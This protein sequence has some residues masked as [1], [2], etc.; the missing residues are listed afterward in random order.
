MGLFL[1][2]KEIVILFIFSGPYGKFFCLRV[3][4]SDDVLEKNSWPKSIKYYPTNK[5]AR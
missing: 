2:L 3:F 4:L 5:N 1:L